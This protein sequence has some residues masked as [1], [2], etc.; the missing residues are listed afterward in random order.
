MSEGG[1]S[2]GDVNTSPLRARWLAGRDADTRALLDADADVFLH[3]SLSTPC[4]DAITGAE[5]PFLI[6]RDG[7]RIFDFHGNSVHQLGHGHPAVVTAIKA[8]LDRLPFCPRRFTCEEAVTFA[9]RLAD[10]APEPLGKVLLAPSGSAAIGMAL[11]LARYA[12]GRHKTLSM[13]DAFHGA[14]LDAISVGGEALFRRDAGPLLP[15]AEHVP[16]P[17]LARRFFGDDDKAPERLADYIDYVLEVQ[18]DVAALIA[19]PVRWTTVEPP[20]PGFWARVK[21]SCARHG[22]LLVFDEIPSALARCGSVYVFEQMACV[23]DMVA[24]GKGLGGGIVPQAALV[25][26][27]DL[28]IA[29]DVA[30]G[31]YTHEKSPLGSAAGLA[32]LDVIAREDLC[33]RALALGDAGQA[34]LAALAA[35]RPEI[36][37]VRHIGAMFGVELRDHGGIAAAV[38]ADRILYAA[39]DRGLSFKVGGGRVLTLCPPLTISD[40]D[41]AAALDLLE[42]A[43]AD[44]EG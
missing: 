10:L 42:A 41:F 27:R 34:R 25:V 32:V 23:P 22:T 8:Q 14:N 6:T 13:W 15:G 35:R 39:L 43:F 38:R 40:A 2:E 33:A 7:R 31:H 24:L 44:A 29:G 17:G 26:R 21:D 30:L 1:A 16:P 5:G 4:L 11:K 28:D 9:T 18:G 37:A 20:P 3:Q 36:A 19:E 12:T